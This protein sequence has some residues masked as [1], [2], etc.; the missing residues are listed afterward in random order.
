MVDMKAEES[1]S[2][3]ATPNGN[4]RDAD[5]ETVPT[6]RK[7]ASVDK[8]SSAGRINLDGPLQRLEQLLK[9]NWSRYQQAGEGLELS[10]P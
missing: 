9:E 8:F 6:V 5:L 1:S 7:P 4:N 10:F 3:L 2:S